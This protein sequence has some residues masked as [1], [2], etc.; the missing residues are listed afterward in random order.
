MHVERRYSQSKYLSF[1]LIFSYTVDSSTR[2]LRRAVW[3]G[4]RGL[5]SQG[6]WIEL[7]IGPE[8]VVGL[9]AADDRGFPIYIFSLRYLSSALVLFRQTIPKRHPHVVMRPSR[10]SWCDVSLGTI[11]D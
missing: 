11:D 4:L 9:Q 7:Q 5:R 6:N 1:S 2:E 8:L 10:S 3:C